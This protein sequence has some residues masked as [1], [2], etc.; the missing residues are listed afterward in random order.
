MEAGR[1]RVQDHA[2]CTAQLQKL[3]LLSAAH[4][5]LLADARTKVESLRE[6]IEEQEGEEEEEEDDRPEGVHMGGGSGGGRSVCVC[7]RERDR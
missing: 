4:A 2:A 3:R 5:P 1:A 7:V 6:A